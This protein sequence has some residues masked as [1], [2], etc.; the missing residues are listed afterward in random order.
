MFLV[1]NKRQNI[2][3][4]YHKFAIYRLVWVFTLHNYEYLLLL[5]I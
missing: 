4:G 2:T 5:Q 1:D 3:I